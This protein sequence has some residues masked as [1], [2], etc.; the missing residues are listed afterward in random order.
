MRPPC[1]NDSVQRELKKRK[2]QPHSLFSLWPATWDAHW[3]NR[4]QTENMK[5]TDVAI[6]SEPLGERRGVN[7]W[8]VDLKGKIELSYILDE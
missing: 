4:T 5:P 2:P 6:R 8:A 1:K 3:P 7:R